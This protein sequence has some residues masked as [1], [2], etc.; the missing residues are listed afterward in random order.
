VEARRRE[1]L[2]TRDR[3]TQ[4]DGDDDETA[5]GASAESALVF[6]PGKNPIPVL[7][8]YFASNPDSQACLQEVQAA[9]ARVH[10]S[11][12]QTMKAIFAALFDGNIKNN[13]YKK[14]DTLALFVQGSKH[15]KIVLLGLVKLL[16]KETKLIKEL[17]HIL[18]GFYEEAILSE[19]TLT[20]WYEHISKSADAKSGDTAEK[21][22]AQALKEG[23]TAFIQWLKDAESESDEDYF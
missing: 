12:T 21:K 22:T 5:E 8:K 9:A 2:G 6:E 19:D 18:N 11:E 17:S 3:L 10:W 1:L 20:K 13:F 15:E 23:C 4:L 16:E 14:C 7:Q